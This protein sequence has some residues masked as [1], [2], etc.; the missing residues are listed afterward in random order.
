MKHNKKIL[1]YKLI[2]TRV[3][4]FFRILLTQSLYYT[5]YNMY[6]SSGGALDLAEPLEL[7]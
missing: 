4:G 2:R 1:L 7:L 5:Y 6:V 3:I